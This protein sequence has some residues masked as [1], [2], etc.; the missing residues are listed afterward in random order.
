MRLG[1][2]IRPGCAYTYRALRYIL[3]QTPAILEPV[4]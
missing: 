3:R 4:M 1:V 2:D